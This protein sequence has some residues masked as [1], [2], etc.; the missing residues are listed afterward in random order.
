MQQLVCHLWDAQLECYS[1]KGIIQVEESSWPSWEPEL[2]MEAP[3]QKSQSSLK[4]GIFNYM[5]AT[6]QLFA[7]RSLQ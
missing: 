5:N 2:E 3:N 6:W 1:W 4:S 7:V